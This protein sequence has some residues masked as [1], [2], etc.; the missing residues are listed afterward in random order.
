MK[1]NRVLHETYVKMKPNRILYKNL[2]KN[3]AK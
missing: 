1:P 2:C 3:E